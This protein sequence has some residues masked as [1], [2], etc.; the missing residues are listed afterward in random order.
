M[1]PSWRTST[2]AAIARRGLMALVCALVLLPTGPDGMLPLLLPF[3]AD[4]D[5][6]DQDTDDVR[7]PAVGPVRIRSEFAPSRHATVQP[8]PT[9]P[10][11][12]RFGHPALSTF[13]PPRIADPMNNGLGSPMH[14]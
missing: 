1:T 4:S 2:I 12:A 9:A 3:P 10:D 11:A 13:P 8:A 5:D 6:G 7:E 14:C